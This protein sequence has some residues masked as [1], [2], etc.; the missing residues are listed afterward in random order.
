MHMKFLQAQVPHPKEITN[1][2]RSTLEFDSKQVHPADEMDLHRKTREMVFS[3]LAHASTTTARLQVSLN[4]V[5]T[6][7]KLEKISS[8]AKDNRIKSLEEL[9]LKIGY[10]PSNVKVVEDIFKKK[11]DDIASLRKKLKFPSTEDSQAK[12]IVDIEGEKEELLKL[13]MEQNA[14]IKEMEQEL[15]RLLKEKEQSTPMEVIPLSTVPLTRVITTTV[16]TT[17]TTEIPSATPL[18]TLEK[19]MEL[20]KSMEEM[21]LQGTEI[22]RLKKEVENLQELKSSYQTSYNIK[23]KA[24]KNIKQ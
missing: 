15:E 6:Q 20:E 4:N 21:A 18:T 3:T 2:K 11:N 1:Y 24:S 17:I 13:I 16:S 5:Q 10:D 22:N 12:E 19:T 23:R 8:F 7:L 9:V 14:E